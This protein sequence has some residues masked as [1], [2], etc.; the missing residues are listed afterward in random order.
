MKR[1]TFLKAI[2]VVPLLPAVLQAQDG[3]AAKGQAAGK[4]AAAGDNSVPKWAGKLQHSDGT[5]V[6]ADGNAQPG[7][8]HT[9]S[10]SQQ[11]DPKAPYQM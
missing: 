7:F 2:P 9:S 4:G 10:E 11:A 3:G 5:V 1:R 8:A 6:D